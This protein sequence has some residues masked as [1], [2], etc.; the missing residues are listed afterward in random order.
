MDEPLKLTTYTAGS[1]IPP[2][3]GTCTFHSA[4]LFRIYEATSG[5]EPLLIVVSCGGR[6]VS[7]LLA[8]IRKSVRRFPPT[9][10]K[11]CEVYG[12]GEY[13]DSGLSKEMLFGEMLRRL[14]D[15]ALR[16]CFLIE[17]R[18]Q[19]TALFAYRLFQDNGYFAVNWLRVYNSLHAP[20]RLEER[21]SPSRLRQVKKGLKSG[22]EVSEAHT[23][24]EIR[25]FARMLH[26]N[27]SSKIR[28]HFPSLEFFDLLEAQ[29]GKGRGSRS[30]IFTVT[31]RGRVIGGSACIYSDDTA[32][33][34][35]SGGLRKSYAR[36]YPGILAVWKALTDARER[37]YR[38]LEF[39]DVGLPFR[40][41]GY[42]EFVLRFGGKQISTRRWFRLKWGWLN[43]L[44]GSLLR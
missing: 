22:A 7:K 2:L 26:H 15:E 30:R 14:T 23:A 43:R 20:H 44:M 18:N 29:L 4:E 16:R 3:P 6:V 27:Y 10:V 19:E 31:Y 28:S 34:W 33:L 13:F 32:Y 38:H 9:F 37:G 39:M 8:V 40:R 24:D 17:F 12:E 41:H 25:E 1:S 36:Q 5:Y 35:F 21:F 42:R 11:R